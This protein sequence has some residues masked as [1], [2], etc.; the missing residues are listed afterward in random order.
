MAEVWNYRRL[1]LIY[2]TYEI[3]LDLERID[4]RTL[5]SVQTYALPQHQP[6]CLHFPMNGGLGP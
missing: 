4:T 3:Y 5:P 2:V 1:M 6:A